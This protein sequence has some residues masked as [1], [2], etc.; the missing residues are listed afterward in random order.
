M[1]VTRCCWRLAHPCTAASSLPVRLGTISQSEWGV[2]PW[3]SGVESGRSLMILGLLLEL[4][5]SLF[6]LLADLVELLHVLKELRAALESN[7]KLGFLVVTSVA[8]GGL[9]IYG[10]CPD[11]FE[12]GVLISK[13]T[14]SGLCL[15]V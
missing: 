7:E 4:V 3:K 11:R 15:E 1:R 13:L 14:K 10:F 2:V 12:G 5:G 9:H 6:V 8:G